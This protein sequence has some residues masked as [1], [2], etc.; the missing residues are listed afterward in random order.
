MGWEYRHLKQRLEIQDTPPLELFEAFCEAAFAD[1]EDME[2][3]CKLVRGR[4][5]T[6]RFYWLGRPAPSPTLAKHVRRLLGAM[7]FEPTGLPGGMK[8]WNALLE[9]DSLRTLVGYAG[10]EPATGR[11]ALL[12]VHLTLY[13]HSTAEL[14]SR[15]LRPLMPELPDRPPPGRPTLLLGYLVSSRE[16]EPRLYMLYGQSAYRRPAVRRYL[17]PL[18]GQR[19]LELMGSHP[20]A[21]LCLKRDGGCM[22]ELA[23]RPS[24]RRHVWHPSHA[25]S[26]LWVPLAKLAHQHPVVGERLERLTWVTVP[27]RAKDWRFPASPA[28]MNLYLR[29]R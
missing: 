27:T 14:H 17:E 8:T 3:S 10:P 23:F 9:R 22:L 29:L 28:E 20:R 1:M 4:L 21:G 7:G 15:L 13:P 24:G 11:P 19:G 25:L 2:W 12:K 5:Q 18:V 16:I 6:D 26:P